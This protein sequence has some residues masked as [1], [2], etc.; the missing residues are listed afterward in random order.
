M[1]AT[2]INALS[3]TNGLARLQ[4]FQ[5]RD[6]FIGGTFSELSVLGL[7]S[8]SWKNGVF[9]FVSSRVLLPVYK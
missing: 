1:I 5:N 7:T 9:S 8:G 4:K 2:T 3:G 6:F